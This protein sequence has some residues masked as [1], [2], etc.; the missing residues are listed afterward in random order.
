MVDPSYLASPLMG[1]ILGSPST[2]FRVYEN[3]DEAPEGGMVRQR[4]P[5]H[6]HRTEDEAW[7]VMEGSLRFRF[8]SE[9]FSA[10]AGTGVLLPK[11]TPHTF[12]NPGPGAT[13][14][15]LVAGPK[16]A[17]LLDVLHGPRRPEPVD[18][19]ALYDSFGLDY[20]E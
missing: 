18:L 20:L 13:R 17:A 3:K 12:W 1:R 4:V 15:L 11:G 9:E 16:T 19:K 6:C 5:F 2:D 14:Y 7:Y 10:G 8:G